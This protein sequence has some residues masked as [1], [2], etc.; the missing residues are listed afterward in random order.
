[1]IEEALASDVLK[2]YIDDGT[3][4][5]ERSTKIYQMTRTSRDKNIPQNLTYI[6]I[7]TSI[8]QNLS[9]L[10]RKRQIYHMDS[11]HIL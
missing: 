2:D 1:M 6:D 3:G 7:D 8:Y 9:I 10:C 4:D 5:F 11:A